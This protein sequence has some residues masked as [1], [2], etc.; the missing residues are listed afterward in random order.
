M[1]DTSKKRL[2]YI[3]IFVPVALVLLFVVLFLSHINTDDN[4][5][6]NATEEVVTTEA[7]TEE[8]IIETWVTEDGGRYYF[9]EKGQYAH[10]WKE[11]DGKKYYFDSEGLLATGIT[12]IEGEKYFLNE[13]GTIHNS[14]WVTTGG[15]KYYIKQGGTLYTGIHEVNGEEFIFGD[16]GQVITEEYLLGLIAEVPESGEAISISDWGGYQRK[17]NAAANYNE[18]KDGDNS[19]NYIHDTLVGIGGYEPTEENKRYISN[20]LNELGED[21]NIGFVVLNLYNGKGV[22]YNIDNSEYSASCIKGPYVASVAADKPDSLKYRSN[23]MKRIVEESDNDGYNSLRGSYGRAP[24]VKWCEE[25]GLDSQVS[26]HYYPYL[27]SRELACLWIKTYY[28]LNMDDTGE[29]IREW[30]R[31]PIN[32]SIYTTLGTYGTSETR[33]Y[34][35]S[36]STSTGLGYLTETK[37]GWISSPHYRS[38]T[39]AGIVYP[40]DGSPYLVVIIS[41]LPAD[42][43]ALEPLCRT[44]DTIYQST[45]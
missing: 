23:V 1:F 26:N 44:L 24:L 15:K 37:A 45:D 16:C 8:L 42:L 10:G 2:I 17:A 14:G 9:D 29:S 35:L 18:D 11:I 5:A 38:T 41:D 19:G 36:G 21:C 7:T 13:D 6:E 40:D 32:G 22:A 43:I 25:L 28:F 27:S 39:D 3:L 30:Y 12:E 4:E 33:P 31:S 34:N 20:R